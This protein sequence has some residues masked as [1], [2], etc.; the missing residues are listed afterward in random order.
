[1]LKVGLGDVLCDELGD[2]EGDV[3]MIGELVCGVRGVWG[4]EL[5]DVGVL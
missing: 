3:V 4:E 1:M 2:V 5:V